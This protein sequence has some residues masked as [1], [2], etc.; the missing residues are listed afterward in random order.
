M[1]FL[2]KYS[3]KNIIPTASRNDMDYMELNSFSLYGE[4]QEKHVK[5][6]VLKEVPASHQE[7]ILHTTVSDISENAL[8]SSVLSVEPEEDISSSTDFVPK[9]DT[10]LPTASNTAIDTSPTKVFAP[11]KKEKNKINVTISLPKEAKA[12][13]SACSNSRNATTNNKT[14]INSNTSM[15]RRR[16]NYTE[17]EIDYVIKLYYNNGLSVREIMRV[18]KMNKSSVSRYAR[19]YQKKFPKNRKRNHDIT[20]QDILQLIKQ[21]NEN[22]TI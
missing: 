17:T 18:T 8:F 10:I 4:D 2:K 22:G 1:N 13:D 21:F 3:K 5:S 12:G 20:E 6:S 7:N 9:K 14:D 16:T 19:L 11:K 15:A